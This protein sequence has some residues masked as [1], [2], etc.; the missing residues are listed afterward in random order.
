MT[1]PTAKSQALLRAE[2]LRRDPLPACNLSIDAGECVCLS[3]PSGVGKTLLLRALAD[4]DPHG[5]RL[6]LGG[7]DSES[8]TPSQWR[9]QVG[10]LAAESRWW[11]DTVGAHLP[12]I[13]GDCLAEVGLS[14]EIL[15]QTPA[16]AS[17]GERQ[18]LAL[19]RLL[20]NH[21]RVLLLDEPTANLDREA[22]GQVESLIDHYRKQ[23]QAGVLW[24]THDVDQIKRVADRRLALSGDGLKEMSV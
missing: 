11:A 13:S 16:R 8:M 7:S 3:G 5:G 21:P 2:A 6:R 23:H 18:R 4:L 22:T 14:A 19:L 9:R 20:V 17:A 12:D 24:V 10:Y 1:H 15:K